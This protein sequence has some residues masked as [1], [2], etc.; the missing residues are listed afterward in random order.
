MLSIK[1]V[2]SVH[3]KVPCFKA[4]QTPEMLRNSGIEFSASEFPVRSPDLNVREH[5]EGMYFVPFS[6]LRICL[7]E[8]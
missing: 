8:G 7:C 6:F 5:N 2:T 1:E 4:L 3:D